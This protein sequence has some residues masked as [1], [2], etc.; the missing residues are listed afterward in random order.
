MNK[1]GIVDYKKMYS[2]YGLKLVLFYFIENHLFDI[3]N[4]TDTHKRLLIKDFPQDLKNLNDGIMYMASFK[5]VINETLSIV[6]E[7]EKNF[8]S[9]NLVDIGS[10][11]E[12]F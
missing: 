8:Q 1:F 3:V 7:V 5:S 9:F 4:K 11:K 10:G 2:K 6:K 12:K